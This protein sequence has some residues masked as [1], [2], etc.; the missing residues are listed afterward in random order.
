M[1]ISIRRLSYG[2]G[3]EISGFDL[4]QP[5]SDETIAEIRQAWLDY[6][7]LLIRGQEITPE[8]QIA[9]T[10]RFGEQEEYPLKHYRLP[11][12]PEIFCLSN[13]DEDGRIT[14]TA[15]VG[16]E[17]HTDMS[18]SIKPALGSILR[19]IEA[20]NYGGTT[21]FSNAYMAYE[22]LSPAFRR[23]IDP[24]Y[25]VHQVFNPKTSVLNNKNAAGYLDTAKIE[26]MLRENP[27]VVQP[28]VRIH[29]ETGRRALYVCEN[30]T[31]RLVGCSEAESEPLLAYL[32]KVAAF[33]EYTYRHAWQPND[34]IMWDNRCTLHMAVPDNDHEQRRLMHRTTVLG[35]GSGEY[36]SDDD[37]YWYEEHDRVSSDQAGGSGRN[38]PLL[39]NA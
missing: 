17:W 21:I 32:F 29:P 38:R 2:I 22:R 12:Y 39:Q 13:M 33:V 18:W 24:L 37:T 16:R 20:P 4:T 7:I 27:P 31:T 6:Q 14:Q 11:G 36:A 30:V 10:S 34:I 19:C 3:A 25:A 15:D 1:A 28:V 8:Q 9:F 23:M 26:E 5:L 35:T